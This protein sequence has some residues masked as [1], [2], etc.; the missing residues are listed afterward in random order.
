MA[1]QK[2]IRGGSTVKTIVFDS[3]RVKEFEEL[4]KKER[5]SMS[6]YIRD[7]VS[8]EL[9]KK[10]VALNNPLNLKYADES[11]KSSESKFLEFST[12]RYFTREEAQSKVTDYIEKY[13]VPLPNAFAYHNNMKRVIEVK[14]QRKQEYNQHQQ[15][16]LKH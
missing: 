11:I 10:E 13:N 2:E 9:E 3:S 7:L 4:C 5:K 12:N 15:Q 14:M 8:Q 6:E 1:R 16:Q